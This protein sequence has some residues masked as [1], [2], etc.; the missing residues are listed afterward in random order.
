M[1]EV[2]ELTL[3]VGQSSLISV[4][5]RVK[6]VVVIDGDIAD[7]E[8]MD[9]DEVLLIG[10]VAGTTDIVLRLES[11]DTICRRVTVDFDSEGLETTLGRL[12]DIYVD[13]EQ[14]GATLAVRGMLPNVE[15]AEMLTEFMTRLGHDWVD[16]TRIPGVRQVQLRVRIA[17]ASRSALRQ[18]AFGG[19]VGGSNFFGGVQTPGGSAFQSAGISPS[20]V[21][22][23]A[24]GAEFDLANAKSVSS[25]TTLFA[26]VPGADLEIFLEALDQN[27]YVRVLAEPNLVASSGEEA[28]FLVGGEFPIPVVQ[29]SNTGGAASVTIE[30]KEFGVQLVFRPEVLG[31]GR[32]RLDVAPEVSE[33]SEI[34]AVT[35]QGFKVPGVTTRRSS[36]TV[37]LGSGQ[38]FAMAG[39][40]R[41]VEQGRVSRIPLLGDLPI[42]GTLFRSVRYEKEQ[43]E[44]LVIVTA[45]LVEPLDDGFDRPV[46]GDLHQTP[47]D[48]NLFGEGRLDGNVTHLSPLARLESLGL[49][50]LVGPGAWRRPDD[51][52]QTAGD[53]LPGGG[54]APR[55]E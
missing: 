3:A 14:V 28:T 32:I 52:R 21:E 40:L 35:I 53:P 39:L 5:E 55:A 1:D 33:L 38:S 10:K 51:E 20:P 7:A 48:W 6:Q 9:S 45:D 41:S 26:G 24:P 27:Q 29:G 43:T 12:F 11:G 47:D 30:Y 25:A 4:G 37:E 44:L 22:R 42:L 15:T 2:E 50:G 8:P 34:G 49:D 46:P 13:V 16:M 54:S 23:L 31:D 18:L 19:V 17:E 36:T